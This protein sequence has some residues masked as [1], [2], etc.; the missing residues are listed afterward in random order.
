MAV[1]FSWIRNALFPRFCASCG[2]EGDWLCPSCG[3]SDA[4]IEPGETVCLGCATVSRDGSLCQS[5]YHHFFLD[6]CLSGSSYHDA[7]L[8]EAIRQWK[9][10]GNGEAWKWIQARLAPRIVPG[11]FRKVAWSVCPV[12]L[13]AARR[14][15]RGF[16][17][18][19][20][21]AHFVVEQTG[22]PFVSLLDRSVWTDPQ[23]QRS[24]E[25]RR[26][27]DLDGAFSL[28][29]GVSVPSAVLLCDDVVTSGATLDAAAKALKE[30]G[31]ETVWAWTLARGGS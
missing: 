14:R 20:E 28:V 7:R 12:P 4:E 10:E 17:Q 23:A 6:G 19:E 29:P 2:E 9:Y 16:D 30:A 1:V 15:E 5:C 8:R 31:V 11:L 3:L 18:A 27:G 22:F 25:D 24:A 13:H 26:A 21:V